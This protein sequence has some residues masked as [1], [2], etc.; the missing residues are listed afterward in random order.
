VNH[1]YLTA[2]EIHPMTVV[3]T[4]LLFGLLPAAITLGIGGLVYATSGRR[5]ARYRPG[6][7]FKFDPVWFVAGEHSSRDHSGGD[8]SGRDHRGG[9]ATGPYAA[10]ALPAG[11]HH[12]AIEAR[13]AAAEARAEQGLARAVPA[14]TRRTGKGGARGTW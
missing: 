6:R 1:P 11:E 3:E 2:Q 4:A 14:S 8:H 10:P 5:S 7:P 12:S 9:E 13:H